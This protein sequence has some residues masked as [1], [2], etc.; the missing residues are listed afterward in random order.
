MPCLELMKKVKTEVIGDR[1]GYSKNEETVKIIAVDEISK[2]EN[3]K[4]KT[5]QRP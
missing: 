1:S 4:N 3:R 5:E 2:G